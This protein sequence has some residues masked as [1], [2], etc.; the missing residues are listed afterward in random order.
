MKD[1]KTKN[2]PNIIVKVYH[3]IML[4][5]SQKLGCSSVNNP[6]LPSLFLIVLTIRTT[7]TS[8]KHSSKVRISASR[9][10]F[11]SGQ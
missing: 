4:T 9:A 2:N 6:Y 1:A 8:A 7:K 10:S 3:Q 5:L 11:G